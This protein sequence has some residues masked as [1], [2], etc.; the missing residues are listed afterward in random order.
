MDDLQLEQLGE[1][2]DFGAE[3]RDAM[4][5]HDDDLDDLDDGQLAPAVACVTRTT[6]NP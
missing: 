6:L 3:Y 1:L 4:E 2:F 5:E